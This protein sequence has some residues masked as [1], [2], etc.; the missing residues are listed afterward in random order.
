MEEKPKNTRKTKK[1]KGTGFYAAMYASLGGLL[2]LAIFIGYYSFLGPGAATGDT[3]VSHVPPNLFEQG[4]AGF[5]VPVGGGFDVPIAGQPT[6]VPQT[7]PP[8]QD[9]ARNQ[10]PQQNVMPTPVE[11]DDGIQPGAAPAPEGAY[12]DYW[13][14]GYADIYLVD[15]SEMSEADLYNIFGAPHMYFPHFAEG[16]NMHWPIAGDILMDF[17]MD[18]LI[19]DA[20]LDQWRTNDNVAIEASRG[21]AV[22]AAAT[23]RVAEITS[24]RQFGQKVVIDHG[25]GWV[26]TY[27][28][29]DP[30]SLVVRVDDVVNRGQIIGSVGSP[31]IFGSMLGYHVGFAIANNDV[32]VDPNVMLSTTS[33]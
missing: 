28:Q 27:T 6:P 12:D 1:S 21:D 20:T 16:D 15:E 14:Y 32:P 29:L 31:S 4:Q 9:G 17:A 24:T 25:N 8:P 3:Q 23:G 10:V 7:T 33:P 5:D 18:R 22:R 2:V 19:F 11:P 30:A 13:D 26:T